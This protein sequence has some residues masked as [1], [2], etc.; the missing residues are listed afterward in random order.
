MRQY[1]LLFV[2]MLIAS[3]SSAQTALRV[4]AYSMYRQTDIVASRLVDSTVYTYSAGRGSGM[5]VNENMYFFLWHSRPDAIVLCDTALIYFDTGSGLQKIALYNTSYD[6]NNNIR[7]IISYYHSAGNWMNSDRYV[8]TRNAAGKVTYEDYYEPA[9]GNTWSY[10]NHKG[11][12]YDQHGNLQLDSSCH[13]TYYCRK[14]IYKYNSAGRL[15]EETLTGNHAGGMFDSIDRHLYTYYADG[16]RETNI[17]CFYN[18]NTSAWDTSTIDS[19]F[20]TGSNAYSVI[21]YWLK[22]SRTKQWRRAG[23]QKCFYN[24]KGNPYLI[25]SRGITSDGSWSR[26]YRQ[27]SLIYESDTLLIGLVNKSYTPSQTPSLTTITYNIYYEPIHN[28]TVN[29]TLLQQTSFAIFP[30]PATDIIH[31]KLNNPDDGHLQI[32]NALGQIMRQV[33]YNAHQQQIEINIRDLAPGNYFIIDSKGES[34]PTGFV[35]MR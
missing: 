23:E 7:E 28:T 34:R 10:R 8:L 18:R 15:K 4:R 5:S 27:D 19:I 16:K 22:D 17:Y 32:R 24:T 1:N 29:E 2:L 9:G 35:I 12:E 31:I 20:Y 6:S 33:G 13:G 30:N 21:V 14:K 11:Y 26:E 3:L 25:T